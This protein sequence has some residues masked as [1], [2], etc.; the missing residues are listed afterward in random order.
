MKSPQDEKLHGSAC[1]AA[2]KAGLQDTEAFIEKVLQFG[3]TIR[4]RH[5][6]MLVGPPAAAK[7]TTYKVL[8]EAFSEKNSVADGVG[9]ETVATFLINPRS[10]T[11]SELYGAFD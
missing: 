11:M 3:D 4:G 1:R 5:G 9:Q 10:L 7:T 8:A 6:V 2:R